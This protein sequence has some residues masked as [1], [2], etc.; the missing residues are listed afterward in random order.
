MKILFHVKSDKYFSTK[1][2]I[3]CFP[4]RETRF[5][6]NVILFYVD[7]YNRPS[8]Y[9]AEREPN[10][11]GRTVPY[12][13]TDH[14][15]YISHGSEDDMNSLYNYLVKSINIDSKYDLRCRRRKYDFSPDIKILVEGVIAFTGK[16]V[17]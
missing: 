8:V 7:S 6:E 2:A 14:V 5:Y 4:I 12:S 9:V 13:Y 3:L 15:Y 17:E 1:R 10:F 16:A 11:G